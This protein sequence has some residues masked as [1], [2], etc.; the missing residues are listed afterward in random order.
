MLRKEHW[1]RCDSVLV[2]CPGRAYNPNATSL[3]FPFPATAHVPLIALFPFQAHRR[4]ALALHRALPLA[5]SDSQ[6]FTKSYC[7]PQD[8]SFSAAVPGGRTAV[9]GDARST[10]Q[11]AR[12]GLPIISHQSFLSPP[13]IQSAFAHHLRPVASLRPD[14]RHTRLPPGAIP[15]AP[16]ILSVLH[17]PERTTP[18][19]YFTPSVLHALCGFRYSP[20]LSLFPPSSSHSNP[21][22][23]IIPAPIH[24]LF[25]PSL[26]SKPAL[27]DPIAPSYL[28]FAAVSTAT[29]SARLSRSPSSRLRGDSIDKKDILLCHSPFPS[30][31]SY[32][33]L[34]DTGRRKI[35]RNLFRRASDARCASLFPTHSIAIL[36]D[37]TLAFPLLAFFRAHAIVAYRSSLAP[38]R[39]R[40]RTSRMEMPS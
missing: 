23:L 13:S 2:L 17:H 8:A 29:V 30:P 6:R 26:T 5:P 4:R 1:A 37:S 39:R 20:C 31:F 24:L 15:D 25:A 3:Q 7:S 12:S 34:W 35:T 22:N 14:T 33:V 36:L 21:A 11:R 32:S 18:K 27:F 16:Q 10:D 40:T 28:S 38:P 9:L 19:A